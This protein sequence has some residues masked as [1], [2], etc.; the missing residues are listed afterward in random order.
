MPVWGCECCS[1]GTG[2]EISHIVGT[3]S[4]PIRGPTCIL[5]YINMLQNVAQARNIV[6][7]DLTPI[8]LI[9]VIVA[10]ILGSSPGALMFSCDMF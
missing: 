2:T 6:D 8:P 5:S 7:R 10:M 4:V 3:V 9:Q 1:S